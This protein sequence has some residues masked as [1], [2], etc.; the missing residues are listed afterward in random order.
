MPEKRDR[1]REAI[2][3]G[4]GERGRCGPKC[5]RLRPQM[6]KGGGTEGGS[7]H[8]NAGAHGAFGVSVV[9]RVAVVVVAEIESGVADEK[10]VSPK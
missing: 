8:G 6:Q 3:S 7:G 10:N 2:N 1:T 4:G 9:R 5:V